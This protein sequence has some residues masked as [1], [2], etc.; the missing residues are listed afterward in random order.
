MRKTFFRLA[1]IGFFLGMI[2][3]NL[4]AWFADGTLVNTRLAAWLDSDFGSVALQTLL[5]GILGAV[6]MGGTV[7]HSIEHWPLALSC[8]VHYLLIEI[9]YIGIAL[10][11]GWVTGLPELLWMLFIQ[12]SIYFL[13]W[14]F[15][16]LRYR[17]Q[18]RELNELLKKNRQEDRKN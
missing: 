8:I 4:I 2:M 17:A 1:G 5:S 15:M 7:V 16:Y 9:P 6:A 3:G 13:I 10:T 14:L 18:V 12:G 11:L